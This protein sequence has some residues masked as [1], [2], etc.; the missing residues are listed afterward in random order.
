MSTFCSYFKLKAVALFQTFTERFSV[1]TTEA[2]L[3][4][5][6]GQNSNVLEEMRWKNIIFRQKLII[7]NCYWRKF[8][9][10]Q[11]HS[12]FNSFYCVCVSRSV[13]SNPVS[14]CTVACQAVLEFSWQEYWRGQPF[15]SPGDLLDPGIEPRSP[16]LQADSLLSEIPGKPLLFLFYIMTT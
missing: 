16:A 4:V 5:L 15:P 12:S 14:L 6:C 2:L 13:V 11:P 1:E 8:T 10:L 9:I 7:F 3:K